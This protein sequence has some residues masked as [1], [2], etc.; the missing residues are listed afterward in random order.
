MAQTKA[1]ACPHCN[2]PQRNQHSNRESGICD[3]LRF[4]RIHRADDNFVFRTPK[5][6]KEASK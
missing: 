5:L 6:K 3:A 1:S 4:N 2:V